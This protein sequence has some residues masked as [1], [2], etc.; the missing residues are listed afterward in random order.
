M[1]KM[2]FVD[3]EH[4]RFYEELKPLA[5]KD[6]YK[7]SL[8]Y[9][10]SISGTTRMHFESIY[11]KKESRIKPGAL[12]KGYQTGTSV[13]ITRLAFN[14]WNGWVYDSVDDYEESKVSRYYAVD[15]IFCC[16]LAPYFWQAIKLRY[17]NY[18]E[19]DGI[20]VEY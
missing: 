2:I 18:C 20:A 11:D 9:V 17:P 7:L 15:E 8:F 19:F 5:G 10:L 13:K 1:S 16:E 14:L 12:K 3:D 6:V 4:K